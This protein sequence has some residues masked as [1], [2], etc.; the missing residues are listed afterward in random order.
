[1]VATFELLNWDEIEV[2]FAPD[3]VALITRDAQR[4]M[5]EKGIALEEV[6]E[7]EIVRPFEQTAIAQGR[8]SFTPEEHQ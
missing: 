7:I 8:K 6:Y 5:G 1:M 4:A 3:T 2:I